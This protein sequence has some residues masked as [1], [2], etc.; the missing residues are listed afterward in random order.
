M[1]EPST[2]MMAAVARGPG[3]LHAA[4]DL[5][6]SFG[7]NVAVMRWQRELVFIEP[8]TVVVYDRADS[9]AGVQQIWQLVSPASFTVNGA[10]ASVTASGHSLSAQRI[11]PAAGAT[12]TSRALTGDFTGGFRYEE[13]SAGGSVR[14][15]H[16]ISLD[17]AVTA[18]T[19]SPMGN[20]DGVS[21]TLAD[22]RSAVV[23]FHQA[24]IGG[25]LSITGGSG[26]AVDA[27]LTSGVASLPERN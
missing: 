12:G 20:D 16:V 10:T 2:S 25:S 15:L 18:A 23:R 22:G 13:S 17:G 7:G 8:N 27:T 6:P 14:H 26:A 5:T 19:S 24:S 9:A 1:R 4:G 21:I 3:W 11:V